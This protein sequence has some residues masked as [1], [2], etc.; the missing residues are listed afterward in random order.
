MGSENLVFVIWLG[1]VTLLMI[2]VAIFIPI[3][4]VQLFIRDWRRR[5]V[6]AVNR[7]PQKQ[8]HLLRWLAVTVALVI[9]SLIYWLWLISSGACD[10]SECRW[11]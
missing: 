5:N 11:P 6:G 9:L 3:K 7:V 4:F 2:A 8:T 10:G 1:A